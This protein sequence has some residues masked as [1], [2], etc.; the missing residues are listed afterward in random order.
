MGENIIPSIVSFTDTERL[1]G[2]SCLSQIN[3]NANNTVFN[4][5]RLIGHNFEDKNI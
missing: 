1:V 3:K 5:M 2:S 4:I